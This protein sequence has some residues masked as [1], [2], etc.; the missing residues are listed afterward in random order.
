[1]VVVQCGV[2][3]VVT[4]LTDMFLG[5]AVRAILLNVPQFFSFLTAS[6]SPPPP[7]SPSSI[8]PHLLNY[9]SRC[10]CVWYLV[11]HVINFN[12]PPTRG[13]RSMYKKKLFFCCCENDMLRLHNIN[14]RN[15]IGTN[16]CHDGVGC[17]CIS[18]WVWCGVVCC[19]VMW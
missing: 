3:V 2:V 12:F 11:R 17:L 1:V 8:P 15:G 19:G 7:L 18:T 4:G 14:I 10:L 16:Q 6:L 9:A 5:S 13:E